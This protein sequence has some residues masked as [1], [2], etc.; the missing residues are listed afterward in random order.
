MANKKRDNSEVQQV[1]E[2]LKNINDSKN[3][4]SE[5]DGNPKNSV[6]FYILTILTALILVVLI[7][8]SIFFFAIK[9]NV[10]GMADNMRGTIE[11]I[12]ILRLALPEEPEPED[13]KNMTEEQVRQKYT[14]LRA[15]KAELQKQVEELQKQ[16][17][18]LN[19]Q[20]TS[21][22]TDSDLL[23]QQKEA[24][25]KAQQ[26][27]AEEYNTLKKDFDDLSAVIA[28]GDPSE[29]KAYFEKID[30]KL[31]AELYEQVLKEQKISNDVKK[32]VSIY[33][34]MDASSVATIMEQMGNG[35]MTLILEIMKNL[36]KEKSAE[37]LSEM[38]PEFAAKVSEQLAKVYNVGEESASK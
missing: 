29:F 34:N 31:A 8:G 13:E 20:L 9:N 30:S 36:K 18:T 27:Q 4:S 14:L 6:L 33:E 28:K 3:V 19:K 16:V 5:N 7:I 24:A 38:T 17:D 22:Q 10:N 12:P 37:I 11:K 2:A 26:K 15:E 35:K 25:E 32:Y 23:L 21:K 1:D